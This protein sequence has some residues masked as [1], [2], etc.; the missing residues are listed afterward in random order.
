MPIQIKGVEL[1]QSRLKR[2]G[3]VSNKDNKKKALIRVGSILVNQMRIEYRRSGLRRVTGDL[4]N[5]LD[6]KLNDE[7]SVVAGSFGVNY[8]ATH[9]YGFNGLQN[10]RSHTR[11][12]SKGSVQVKAHTRHAVIP[13]RPFIR[14]ALVRQR[15]KIAEIISA[16]L[17]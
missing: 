8:A 12:T 16:L 11:R 9:E 3:D 13:A 6:F 7:N 1:L 15:K 10:I 4:A 17:V 14:P 5:S 2:L